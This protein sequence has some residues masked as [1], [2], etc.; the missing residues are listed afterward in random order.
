MKN[1]AIQYIRSTV[2]IIFFVG[3]STSLIGGFFS[4]WPA[5]LLLSFFLAMLAGNFYC[6]W[7][8]PFGSL[9]EWLGK[10][11]SLFIKKKFR[12]PRTIQS[13]LQF[14]RY[15]VY[16][17]ILANGVLGIADTLSE[18]SAFNSNYYFAS[19]SNTLASGQFPQI[20]GTFVL[21]F[22]TAYLSAALFF[23][24]PF[25]NYLCPD[26][27]KYGLLSFMRIF[28]IRRNE[29][30]CINCKKCSRSCPMQIDVANTKALRNANCINCMQCITACPVKHALNYGPF[31]VKK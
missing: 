5:V 2:Q 7:I 9:Q 22:L 6:G 13:I 12:M 27:V 20:S 19:L 31:W 1:K 14:S 10:F 28:T 18:T 4:I 15:I 25:C 16:A 26:G 24:R 21:L 29:S 11:S 8:C 3:L 17:L 30:K 23:D